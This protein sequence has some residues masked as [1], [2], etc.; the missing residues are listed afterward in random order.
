MKRFRYRGIL[1]LLLAVP[2][3]LAVALPVSAA[4]I[5]QGGTVTVASNQTVNDDLYSFGSTITI[6]GTIRGDVVALGGTIRINGTVTGSVNAAGSTITIAGQVDGSMR[7][8]GSAITV[9]GSIGKDALLAGSMIN[10]ASRARI[11]R[12]LNVA[13]GTLNLNGYVGR[14]V[15]ADV[16][17]LHVGS[18]ATVQGALRYGNRADVVPG[19]ALR[20]PITHTQFGAQWPGTW[21]V[22]TTGI[23]PAMLVFA[24]LRGFIS[25]AVLG[26]LFLLVASRYSRRTEMTLATRPWAS[27]GIG[28]GVLIGVPIAIGLAFIVGV[29]VGGWWLALLALAIYV[30][31]IAL[32]IPVTGLFVG[33]WLLQRAGAHNTWPGARLI[34]GLTL[35]MLA[36][37]VPILGALVIFLAVLCGLG[38]LALSL[39]TTV[40]GATSG[41]GTESDTASTYRRNPVTGRLQYPEHSVSA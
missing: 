28:L 34:L 14:N 22:W 40:E 18:T 35:L 15:A 13:A 33:R 4:Q 37:L 20:G 2:L 23:W 19:A 27:L 9:D 36:S 7:A 26:M 29:F 25:L 32:S 41:T 16:Q 38:T 8:A 10:L 6:D 39:G 21:Q 12:D 1:S 3:L 11:G 31:A 5:T 24:W 30:L 17:T